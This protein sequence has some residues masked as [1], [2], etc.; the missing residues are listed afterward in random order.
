MTCCAC[1]LC[2]MQKDAVTVSLCTVHNT[3]AQQVKICCHD[4]DNIN[5]DTHVGTRYVTLAKH[6]M[7]LPD[8]SF[9]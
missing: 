7:W 9:M 5:N 6:W 1:V 2:T 3:H 8:N 4:T